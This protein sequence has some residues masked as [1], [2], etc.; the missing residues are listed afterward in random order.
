MATVEVRPSNRSKADVSLSPKP[1]TELTMKAM[2]GGS[3]VDFH[4][5]AYMLPH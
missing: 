5:R 4:V 3:N 1:Q 2:R